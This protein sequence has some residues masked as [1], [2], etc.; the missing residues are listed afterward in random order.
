MP[1]LRKTVKR[2]LSVS[3]SATLCG[4][5]D[6][7]T[8]QVPEAVVLWSA[9]W[10][11]DALEAFSLWDTSGPLLL[12]AALKRTRAFPFRGVQINKYRRVPC[13]RQ[14]HE[15]LF[16]YLTWGRRPL[17]GLTLTHPRHRTHVVF[18]GRGHTCCERPRRGRRC[19]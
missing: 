9:R 19:Y 16:R 6:Q 7:S 17:H 10:A 15:L 14:Q 1:L 13:A 12:T 4:P 3:G 11:R 8:A 18:S 2:K 5:L